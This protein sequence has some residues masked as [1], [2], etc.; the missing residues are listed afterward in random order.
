MFASLSAF[1]TASSSLH[2]AWCVRSNFVL[3]AS[4][5]FALAC[6]SLSVTR[7]EAHFVLAAKSQE[8]IKCPKVLYGSTERRELDRL[9]VG[10]EAPSIR[11]MGVSQDFL[12][13]PDVVGACVMEPP[14]TASVVVSEDF[15]MNMLVYNPSSIKSS[16][17]F[18]TVEKKLSAIMCNPDHSVPNSL[19][20]CFDNASSVMTSK[21]ACNAK[22]QKH[23]A[24]VESDSLVVGSEGVINMSCFS[25]EQHI[26]FSADE[27]DSTKDCF[28]NNGFEIEETSGH[29][30]ANAPVSVGA[31]EIV[32]AEK[33]LAVTMKLL[34]EQQEMVASLRQELSEKVQKASEW[35]SK[36]LT[37]PSTASLPSNDLLGQKSF[38]QN[39]KHEHHGNLPGYGQSNASFILGRKR[40]HADACS[41]TL[42][43]DNI[44]IEHLPHSLGPF[45]PSNSP[46]SVLSVLKKR[47]RLRRLH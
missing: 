27:I 42:P 15:S 23:K 2:S 6:A 8:L 19:N 34:L 26:H 41:F 37:S 45:A 47:K 31:P 22:G 33:K 20:L 3:A 13:N 28:Q 4:A 43:A 36:S 38:I 9:L 12:G 1:R 7:K 32:S 46:H 21:S 11:A 35:S 25:E 17:D 18:C 30:I 10:A 39:V 29:S 24:L 40:T 16:T 5:A 14:L 44:G